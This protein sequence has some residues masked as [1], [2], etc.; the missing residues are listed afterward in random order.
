MSHSI[1]AAIVTLNMLNVSGSAGEAFNSSSSFTDSG[2]TF[3]VSATTTLGSMTGRFSANTTSSGV[4]SDG[5]S[6]VGGDDTSGMD[7]GETLNLLIAFPTNI[8]VTLTEIDFD[9]IGPANGDDAALVS[10]GGNS[11]TLETGATNFNGSSDEWSPMI[12]IN[13]GNVISFSAEDNYEII[14]ISFDIQAVPEPTSL[15]MF[16]SILGFCVRRRK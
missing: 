14:S 13:D 8:D 12:S 5:L 9:E 3:S 10:V 4:D 6:G 7:A 16:A 1:T 15:V 2:V 11:F